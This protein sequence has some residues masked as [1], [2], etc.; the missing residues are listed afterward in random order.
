MVI[1]KEKILL[2]CS[3]LVLS[4]TFI[5]TH[6]DVDFIKDNFGDALVRKNVVFVSR[7][8][9]APTISDSTGAS[10]GFV[11]VSQDGKMILFETPVLSKTNQEVTISYY[12]ENRSPYDVEMSELSC[13]I[14]E[15]HISNSSI[16]NYVTV[17]PGNYYSGKVIKA[18]SLTDYSDSI[19]IKLVKPYL[20]DEVTFKILC[21]MDATI[22]DK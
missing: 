19:K 12:L 1:L 21:D 6:I 17:K 20:G 8:D 10:G 16:S 4:F 22:T 13:R 7:G 15:D 2:L 3:S 5:F 11:E 9:K 18:G 14:E